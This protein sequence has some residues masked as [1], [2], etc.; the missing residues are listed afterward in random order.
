MA[1]HIGSA[2]YSITNILASQIIIGAM[3]FDFL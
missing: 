1:N 2:G 3:W